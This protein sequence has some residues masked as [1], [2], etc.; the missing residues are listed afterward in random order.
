M[1]SCDWNEIIFYVDG[2]NELK[3]N[4]VYKFLS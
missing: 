4:T 3:L 2:I 1:E